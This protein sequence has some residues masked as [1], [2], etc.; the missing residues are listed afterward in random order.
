MRFELKAVGPG[1]AVESLDFQA[2]DEATAVQAV[3]G[4]GYT[5]LSVRAKRALAWRGRDSRFPLVLFSQELRV[6]LNA[7]LPLVE[8]IDT[9]AEKERSAEWRALLARLA[10]TMREGRPFS[11]A[12]EQFP[13][14]FPVLYIA[15]VRAAER[16][17]DLGPSLERYVA[18]AT[19][20]EAIR[21]RVVNASIYPLLLIGVGG[22]VSL[23]LLLYVVPRFGRIYEERGGDLPLF[24]RLLLAWGQAIDQHAILVLGTVGAL[25]VAVIYLFKT[26]AL[27]TRITD[28]LWRLPAIGERL[29]VYQL[30][31]FYRTIGMLVRGGMPLVAALEMGAE[32]L[33]PLLRERLRAA[34]R[35]IS[36]GGKLSQ[37]MDA[38]G[39]TTPVA[40]RLLAVG[41]QGGNIG[42]MLEQ[43]AAFHDEELARWVDWFT[44]LFEPI[45]MALIGLVIGAIVIL[46]YMP[47]FELAGG[48]Q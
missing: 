19:Q 13:R 36:E 27:K 10:A 32:L 33:H 43:I 26:T 28:A 35:A 24:S 48:L 5:V 41:E 23:F 40:L 30:A 8:S 22:L 29:K 45:L 31:R 20:L 3:E 44:R 34:H 37:S 4:R 9:L 15:T 17:S 1:G 2:P 47:I 7:G 39:L 21:K 12:L 42:E 11:A 18:Y 38:N 46:M 14:A 16:T 25:I 6:L